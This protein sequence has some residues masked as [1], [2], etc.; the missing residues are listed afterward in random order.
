VEINIGNGASANTF[1][2]C[3]KLLKQIGLETI[4]L[5]AHIRIN[6]DLG[7]EDYNWFQNAKD[8]IEEGYNI[9]L[10]YEC[11]GVDSSLDTI[12]AYFVSDEERI[13]TAKDLGEILYQRCCVATRD[14]LELQSAGVQ[15]QVAGGIL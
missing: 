8:V 2:R 12:S 15:I 6:N 10:K 14:A 9:T 4:D 5:A 13:R 3:S 11:A 1:S 7:R